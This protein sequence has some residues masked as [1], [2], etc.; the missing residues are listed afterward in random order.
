MQ[1]GDKIDVK[2]Y[3]SDGTCYR[4]WTGTVEAVA[5]DEIVVITPPHHRVEGIDGGWMS[6]YAIRSYY[7]PGTWYSL[8]EAYTPEGTLEEIYINSPVEIEGGRIAFT[9]YELDVSRRLPHAAR[10]VDQ[11]EFLEAASRYGYSEAFQQ[12]C[13]QV[14]RQAIELANGWAAKGMP[15]W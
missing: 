13:Y 14:A 1:V 3:K 10:I 7:W 15:E 11:D 12:T 8:L 5:D 9:D 4:W 6:R 2:A